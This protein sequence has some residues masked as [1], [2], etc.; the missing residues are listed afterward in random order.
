MAIDSNALIKLQGDRQKHADAL[1]RVDAQ[2]A[3]LRAAHRGDV[4]AELRRQVADYG[5]AV[6]EVFGRVTPTRQR[7]RSV[8]TSKARAIVYQDENGN[9]WSGGK[10]PRPKWIKALLDA[11]KDIE[12]YRVRSEAGA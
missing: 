9:T 8:N 3:E 5:F 2:I 12:K 10:G 7:R 6:E 11:G 4:L 1:A